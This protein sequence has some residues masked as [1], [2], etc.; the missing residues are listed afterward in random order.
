MEKMEEAYSEKGP[1]VGIIPIA[2]KNQYDFN[3]PWPNCM[4]PIADDYMLI[5]AA[6]AECAWAG[7]KSIW[8]V[9]NDDFAPIIRK[10]IG[11]WCGDPVWAYRNMDPNPLH[12]KRRIPIFYTPTRPKDRDK[13]D[14]LSW[15][16]IHGALQAFKISYKISKWLTPS[17]YYV[18]FPHGYFDPRQIRE[19]RRIISSSKNCYLSCK[20]RTIK[21]GDLIS[22]TFSKPDWLEF[23][24]VVRTGTGKFGPN[25]SLEH[26][27]ALPLEERWSA[28]NFSVDKVFAPLKFEESNEIVVENFYNVRSWQEYA[29]FISCTR[30]DNIKKPKK[31]ILY[32]ATYNKL[33]EYDDEGED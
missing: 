14:S 31:S 7:C 1:L 10:R 5:E 18:S 9:V 22:F 32:A 6:V 20:G 3:M 2:S 8:I 30:F 4:M 21:D 33:G 26:R 15:S 13:R 19:H 23:R 11:D 25:W 12:S 27:E 17:K 24:R 16:V 29:D 28:V